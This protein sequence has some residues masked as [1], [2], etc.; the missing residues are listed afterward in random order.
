MP[1][2]RDDITKQ[3]EDV[4]KTGADLSREVDMDYRRLSGILLG[5]W[6]ARPEEERKIQSVLRQWRNDS[7][8]TKSEE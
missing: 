5:Y 7:T 8:Q 6:H 2:K 3:C 1:M 4:G